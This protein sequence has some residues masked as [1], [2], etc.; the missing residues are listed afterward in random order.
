MAK[1]AKRIAR[2]CLAP[3]MTY[4]L[5][6][7]GAPPATVATM[8]KVVRT[9]WSKTPTASSTWIASLL[10]EGPN[11]MPDAMATVEPIVTWA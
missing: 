1:L 7:V 6:V 11:Q 2:P 4:G 9:G 3:G 10:E 8:M 5:H